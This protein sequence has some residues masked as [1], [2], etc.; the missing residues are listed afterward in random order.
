MKAQKKVRMV[1][2]LPFRFDA[3]VL[4]FAIKYNTC[5]SDIQVFYFALIAH[6]ILVDLAR[7][8]R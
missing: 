3:I 7:E 6:L 8:L 2:S 1:R 4:R 5:I